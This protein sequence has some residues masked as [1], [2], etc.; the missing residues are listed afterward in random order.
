MHKVSPPSLPLRAPAQYGREV[1]RSMA[2]RA[3][4]G[5][6]ALVLIAVV[7]GAVAGWRSPAFVVVEAGALV[8]MLV[9]DRVLTPGIER[10]ERGNAAELEVAEIIVSAAEDGWRALHDVRFG[11]GNIDHVLIGPGGIL[12]VETKSRRGKVRVEDLDERWLK[13]AYAEAKCLERITGL[14]AQPLLVLSDA[15][16]IGRGVSR[17]RGVCVLPARM[18]QGFLA[19][20]PQQLSAAEI[21]SI[22]TRLAMALDC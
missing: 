14:P 17:R 2:Q 16:L 12:T 6:A 8:L 10:R 21:D 3:L 22:H 15:F 7:T 1:V 20:R 5:L 11:R 19:R 18:L 13:Q 9:G 4:M